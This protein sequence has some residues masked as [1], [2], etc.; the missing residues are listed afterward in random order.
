MFDRY[1][2]LTIL[3]LI[4]L[5]GGAF[6]LYELSSVPPSLARD[7]VSVGYNAYSILK[8]GRD[9]YG[10]LLP[11]SFEA[12]GDWKL[13]LNVYF[14]VPFI[15][16]FGLTELAVRLPVAL[17]G[18]LSIVLIFLLIKQLQE[19]KI[20]QVQGD[21]LALLCAFLLAVSP[22]HIYMSR[23][24]FGHNTLAL[25]FFLGG[26]YFWLGNESWKK[27]LGSILLGTT[28][29]FYTS[30]HLFLPLFVIGFLLLFRNL[31]SQR[32][33]IILSLGVV[34]LLFVISQWS[35]LTANLTKVS[36]SSVLNDATM[37]YYRVERKIGEHKLE[38]GN[39]YTKILH[40]KPWAVFT[41]I[42]LNYLNV[43]SPQ[44]LFD[45]GGQ[46]PINN[47]EEMGN[48]Y[49]VDVFLIAVGILFV[50]R[51]KE[52]IGPLLFLILLLAPLPGAFT[53]DAPHST[54]TLTLV[55]PILVIEAYGLFVLWET[56]RNYKK[57]LVILLGMV[58][59]YS[60]VLFAE[61]YFYHFPLNRARF[62]GYGFKEA[63]LLAQKM[64]TQVQKV[65]MGKKYDYPYIYFLFYNKYDPAKY[66]KEAKRDPLTWDGFRPVTAFSK[67]YFV[68]GFDWEHVRDKSGIL[69]IDEKERVPKNFQVDGWLDYPFGDHA[70][71]YV[72]RP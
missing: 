4:V 39:L 9:E 70:F 2:A 62:W 7:E 6:R 23:T 68:E 52:K 64:P 65:V 33:I 55:I 61:N 13:P 58:Y 53:R 16:V 14:A 63:A 3:L 28:L 12:F 17:A 48:F 34:F 35:L 31:F 30:Y 41:Q 32:K 56:L 18:T 38:G 19:K 40:N 15:A 49:L 71:G 59:L 20:T 36:G 21:F 47:L 69:Y 45:K 42:G 43:F 29:F 46:N 8:T 26:V 24:G 37:I 44:F 1:K 54:R 60:A 5:L 67:Y 10:R 51:K 66:Q 57:A 25:F 27:Y 50:I 72:Y 22:W 11:L